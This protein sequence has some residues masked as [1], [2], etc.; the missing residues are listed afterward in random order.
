[1]NTNQNLQANEVEN[2]RPRAV[3]APRSDIYE[4]KEAFH[5]VAD[6]PGI[7]EKTLDVSLD[8]NALT[9]RG[10]FALETPAGHEAVWREFESGDYERSFRLLGE[11]DAEG[12]SASYKDGVLRVAVP[13]K[14]RTSKRIQISVG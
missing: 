5:L 3:F 4:S 7:D 9:I 11:V 1:M 13:K 6:M 12:I 2:A 8:R 10:S 14:V